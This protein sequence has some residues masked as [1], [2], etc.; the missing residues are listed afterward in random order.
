MLRYLAVWLVM[1]LPAGVFAQQGIVKGTVQDSNRQPLEMATVGVQG[2]TLGVQTDAQGR[3]SLKVPAAEELV[4]VVRYLGYKQQ[5]RSVRIEAGQE[6]VLD[7]VLEADPQQLRQVD[8]RGKREDD[9]REQVSV[10]RLDPTLTKTLPSA[11]GDF[12]MILATLPGVT[13]NN[14][15]SS[16]YSVRGGNYDENLVYVNGIEIYRPFL[17][18]AAQQEGLSF[19]NPDLVANVEFSSGGWQP[20]YG[21]K[22]SSVLNIQYKR[23]TSF[24]GSVTGSLTG[25]AI[26]LEEA[27][28]NKR[29]SYLMG[30][31]HKNSQYM[32][33]GLQVDGQYRPVFTDGQV[34]LS[35]DLGKQPER[36]TLGLLGSYA[37]NNFRVEPETRT[38]TFG[39]RQAPLRLLVAYDGQENMEYDTYQMGAHLSHQVSDNLLTEFI[40]SGVHSLEREFRDIEALYRLCDVNTLGRNDMGECLRD[41]GIG[42]QF[43][44][45]R[46][47]LKA[48]VL[49]AES[50]NTWRL[51]S[52]STVLTGAKASLERINDRLSEYGFVDSSDFVTM[53]YNLNSELDL[54]TQRYN[55]YVQHTYELDSLKTITYGI[56][57]SYWSYNN[58]LTITPRVQYSF[59]TSQNPDLSFKAAIGLYYQPPFYRE[60]RNFQGELN[61]NL[62]AQRSLHAVIGSDYLFKAWDR[63]F[64]LTTEAYYK[65]MTN[66]VPY[67]LD[68]VRL[69]YYGQNNAK[70]YA[71]GLDVRV[72]GEFIQGAE[73]W[74]SLGLMQTRENVQGDS[75]LVYS[76]SGEIIGSK[77][78]GYL[79]R[80]TD[81]LVNIGVFFQ[82]HLPDNP[83]IRMY[84][85]AVYGSGL[86]FGPPNRPEFRNA[87]SGKSYKRVDIGFSKLIALGDDLTDRKK[88][89]LE[90]LW[91]GLEVLNIIDAQNRISY[92]YLT[93]VNEL[94]YAI[95]NFLTG[96]RV[97]LRF[98]AR[99]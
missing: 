22:L 77:D 10:T 68:N 28:K 38:T 23:P 84:L 54:H 69:R 80:P 91:I 99:F 57:A 96:R 61:P 73:S 72:N 41:R 97:N 78:R 43:D 58:E 29:I 95:P 81:Q 27:S 70:A 44:H 92:S 20:K 47:S 11:F 75:T 31:R 6:L 98:I 19:V 56:R 59:I 34:Y 2:R 18:S 15:L 37:R 24:A 12:N 62:K 64:K 9:T 67:D 35:F 40:V 45:A 3:Y 42:S 93:D 50:R 94:T 79:R 46:N 14:E 8:V 90:S 48:L 17:I 1:L 5:E 76:S 87:F 16:T 71:A 88:V 32:L 25:G 30:L 89:S 53:T 26:H 63:D 39:T 51:S 82:D 33:Q 52:R 4:L 66:V 86:P 13:S 65:H 49:A 74:L 60:L 55:G 21:D 85:N 83:T 7:F 36:T